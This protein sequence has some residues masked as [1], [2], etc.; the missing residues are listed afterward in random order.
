MV[1]AAFGQD[2][3][4]EDIDSALQFEPGLFTWT[5][6]AAAL[7][8]ERINGVAIYSQL[9][10]TGALLRRAKLTSR[11]IGDPIGIPIKS[12]TQLP[13]LRENAN[14]RTKSCKQQTS[15][16]V[17]SLATKFVKSCLVAI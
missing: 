10:Y 1:L 12:D 3:T 4:L 8:A 17:G 14:K 2:M 13:T 16:I 9:N 15:K 6:S 7:L 11:S 5:I